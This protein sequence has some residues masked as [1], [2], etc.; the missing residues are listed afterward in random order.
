MEELEQRIEAATTTLEKKAGR[1]GRQIATRTVAYGRSRR[2]IANQSSS[3]PLIIGEENAA[4]RSSL[5][6]SRA[7]LC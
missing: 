5:A 1:E 3:P 6:R 4:R 2:G 7:P